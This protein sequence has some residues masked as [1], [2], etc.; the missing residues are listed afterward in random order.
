MVS[1]VRPMPLPSSRMVLETKVQI[2]SEI[3]RT[4][5]LDEHFG[6]SRLRA[7][8]G[9]F[10]QVACGHYGHSGTS[11]LWVVMGILVQ[12][13][14]GCY[15]GILVQADCDRY[16][17]HFGTSHLWPLCGHFGKSRL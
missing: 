13:T 1:P 12:A 15:M 8:M 5:T 7:I 17:W 16:N 2:T 11:R 9:I 3:D 4:K 14:Y 6:R 10:E